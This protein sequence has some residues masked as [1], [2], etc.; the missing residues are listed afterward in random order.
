MV[1]LKQNKAK[2]RCLALRTVH[3]QWAHS[4]VTTLT[5]AFSFDLEAIAL[6]TCRMALMTRPLL[7]ITFP[8]SS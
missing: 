5:N 8:T 6:T 1:P 7:P 4:G 2:R 3:E